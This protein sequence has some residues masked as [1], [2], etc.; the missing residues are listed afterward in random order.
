MTRVGDHF[1]F[2]TEKKVAQLV[3]LI[4]HLS[5]EL[6]DRKYQ[7]EL[8]EIQLNL[9]LSEIGQKMEDAVRGRLE[10]LKKNENDAVKKIMAQHEERIKQLQ[11][12]LDAASAERR[13]SVQQL[14]MKVQKETEEMGIVVTEILERLKS[15]SSKVD[16]IAERVRE[17]CQARVI[18]LR[19]E[20]AVQVR[21]MN[22]ESQ[23]QLE[24]LQVQTQKKLDELERD[25][26]RSME[27]LKSDFGGGEVESGGGVEKTQSLA[28]SVAEVSDVVEG[29][30]K[31]FER[32]I[33]NARG[34]V[35]ECERKTKEVVGE[36][37]ES[38]G[39]HDKERESLEQEMER[40]EKEWRDE[41][42]ALKA[43]FE[44][45]ALERMGRISGI[46]RELETLR[47]EM[48][49]EGRQVRGGLKQSVRQQSGDLEKVK[50]ELSEEM[51]G[52]RDEYKEE[53]ESIERR[54]S[55]LERLIGERRAPMEEEEKRL[56]TLIDTQGSEREALAAELDLVLEK[57][58]QEFQQKYEQEKNKCDE[59]NSPTQKEIEENRAVLESLMQEKELLKRETSPEMDEDVKCLKEDL[60]RELMELEEKHEQTLLSI[61]R[62]E[63]VILD[64]AKEEKLQIQNEYK[65]KLQ[66]ESLALLNS[67]EV[68]AGDFES[69]INAEY[70][71]MLLAL[72]NELESLPEAEPI[73][74]SMVEEDHGEVS[75]RQAEIE[76]ERNELINGFMELQK[77]EENRHL[78]HLSSDFSPKDHDAELNRL[79]QEHQVEIEKLKA[80]EIQ[81]EAELKAERANHS[82]TELQKVVDALDLEQKQLES[83]LVTAQK[84]AE[85][86]IVASEESLIEAKKRLA[87]K[88]E[89]TEEK[90]INAEAALTTQ[91]GIHDANADVVEALKD[92][93]E[94]YKTSADKETQ[95]HECEMEV[96]RL[97]HKETV[98]D[99]E[100]S[101]DSL[102]TANAK[103]INQ[104][105][106][107][108][109]A[110]QA[111]RDSDIK[112][113][114]AK[115]ADDLRKFK[116]E[117]D[118]SV[119]L[120]QEILTR[121]TRTL[122]E[123]Q[124]N[125]DTR[126][127]NTTRIEQLENT[128]KLKTTHLSELTKD[129]VLFKK[130]IVAQEGVYNSRFGGPPNVAVLRPQTANSA[131]G[132]MPGG[133]RSRGRMPR[134]M[135]RPFT[136]ASVR[137]MLLMHGRGTRI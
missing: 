44:K 53:T 71:A 94:Q 119:A 5:G 86:S 36:I 3:K 22:E 42:D 121:K 27:A 57:E 128:L 115:I 8:A 31:E 120:L 85:E 114:E 10:T 2:L 66:R 50:H 92:V 28:K 111:T 33:A 93:Q 74:S 99:L 45:T 9:G 69:Q 39:K 136:S 47:R 49:E 102:T 14:E 58:R 80:L 110:A 137:P 82:S 73:V 4:N 130:Q 89:E 25:F 15:E 72:T 113:Q 63:Q 38:E 118:D 112:R 23:R 24:A 81:L 29:S 132:A 54:I 55:E 106:A 34:V 90:M 108:F 96:R 46:Q 103:A 88:I 41:E 67:T 91:Q 78:S 13:L 129:L 60:E 123:L 16:G 107:E 127:E 32:L 43:E 87:D 84:S 116:Q 11:R 35:S 52:K 104:L 26:T 59:A 1:R 97:K 12:D 17:Q 70:E 19:E 122:K 79:K 7:M 77:L 30:K 65:E 131:I 135:Q 100:S 98:K 21:A 109:D 133:G 6:E 56:R 134:P 48:E 18:T 83:Q 64:A 20:H 126:D 75:K 95:L 61:E 105:Q 117:S 101:I 124:E 51:S 40:L 62:E 68:D 37:V 125:L 76:S